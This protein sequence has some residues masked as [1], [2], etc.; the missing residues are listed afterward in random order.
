MA[1]KPHFT[2]QQMIEAL[3]ATKGMVSLAAKLIGCSPTTVRSYVR[4]YA[5]VAA[6]I[7]DQREEVTDVAELSLFKAIQAGEAWAVCFYLK[8]QGKDRG[9]VERYET[10]LD[11]TIRREAEKLAGQL[12][13]N[14][15]DVLDEAKRILASAG[16]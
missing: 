3:T 12:G 11:L 9:Y 4:R 15:D 1:D 14:Y 10:Q 8:T 2:A 16:V 7:A 6:A 13:L 5:S